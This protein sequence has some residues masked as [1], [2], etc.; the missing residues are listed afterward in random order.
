MA[1]C[2]FQNNRCENRTDFL[3]SHA[4]RKNATLLFSLPG[5]KTSNMTLKEIRLSLIESSLLTFSNLF[6][7]AVYF[8]QV[9][10]KGKYLLSLIA[11]R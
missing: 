7:L 9:T 8:W 6:L 10:E 4:K 2:N 11:G 1:H 5:I 3:Q